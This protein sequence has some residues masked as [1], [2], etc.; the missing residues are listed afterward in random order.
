MSAMTNPEMSWEDR[1]WQF[2]VASFERCRNYLTNNPNG[3]GC[4]FWRK[5][6]E[7]IRAK[8]PALKN[9]VLP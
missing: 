5:R 8:W 7:E 9:E 4:D 6:A 3:P 2:D 1:N